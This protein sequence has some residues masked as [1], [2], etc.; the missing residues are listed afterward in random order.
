[1]FWTMAGAIISRGLTFIAGVIVARMLGKTGYG[2]FG[3]IN[4]TVGM[5]GIFAGFGLGITATKHVAEL[6]QKDPVRAGR[7]LGLSFIV[8]M[9]TGGAMA[10]ALFLFAPWLAE[11]TINAPHLADVLK[12]GALILFI[13]ALNG[14]QTGALAGFEAFKTI[15]HVNFFIG[16]VSFPLLI[17]GAYLGGLTGVVWAMTINLAIGWIINHIAIR[18]EA[19]K[20]RVRL[21]FNECSKEMPVL[22]KFSL[23]S[24]L[25][26]LMVTPV[27]WLCNAFLVNQPN[28]Y[29]EMGI[30]TACLVFQNLL[31]FSSSMLD[32]PL[33]SIVS[34]AGENIS[35]KLGTVNIL[36]TW[37]IGVIVA[38]PLLCFPEIPNIFFGAPFQSKS[39]TLTFVII[40]FYTAI[41]MYKAGLA[42]VLTARNLLWWGLLS[43][44]LWAIILVPIA[45]FFVK[46]GAPGLAAA[47]AIAYIANTF[48]FIPFYYS[49][50]L[51][52]KDTILSFEAIVIWGVLFIL[53]IMNIAETNILFRSIAFLPC[54][55]IAGIAFIRIY[56]IENLK[57][58]N[59]I[60]PY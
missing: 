11:N 20:H 2:E 26:G 32:A 21:T 8:A 1:M 39:F 48:I 28:G 6:R 5:F 38:I 4:S 7:I 47:F 10:L 3:M 15:A 42:R 18:K 25:S 36:S 52:P 31:I 46:W 49:R 41:I 40:I 50:N 23:P 14:A 55:I 30:F 29:A 53:V 60:K 43:N 13:S 35:A 51:V 44:I 12:I 17:T 59:N 45:A 57:T 22:W 9:V 16:I 54:I 33:M 56:K 58:Q 34:N 19:A 24:V 27:I 37:L